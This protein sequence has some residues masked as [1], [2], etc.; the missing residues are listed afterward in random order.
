MGG[1]ILWDPLDH[2]TSTSRVM[3]KKD[4]LSSVWDELDAED[5]MDHDLDRLLGTRSAPSAT[6]P[7]APPPLAPPPLAPAPTL[8]TGDQ[9]QQILQM[10]AAHP[11]IA[12]AM[13]HTLRDTI[14]GLH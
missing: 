13:M 5:A 2:S 12:P 8:E 14:A 9:T 4:V 11:S 3:E 7:P 1:S 10:F 6:A